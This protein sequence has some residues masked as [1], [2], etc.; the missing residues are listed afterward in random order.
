MSVN[1][2]LRELILINIGR[3]NGIMQTIAEDL[4]ALAAENGHPRGQDASLEAAHDIDIRAQL[5]RERRDNTGWH[6]FVTA[7]DS[8]TTHIA[9]VY[10]DGSIYLPEGPDVVT[11]TDFRMAAA[12]GRFWRLE[13]AGESALPVRNAQIE[14]VL[15]LHALADFGECNECSNGTPY[16]CPTVT[17]IEEAGK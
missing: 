13:R 2:P 12:T 14:A 3:V 5:E 1:T 17:A 8:A 16:P 11:A 7:D 4:D 6:E 15:E 9:Y 10:E